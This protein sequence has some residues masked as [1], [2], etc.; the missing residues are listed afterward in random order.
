MHIIEPRVDLCNVFNNACHM[1]HISRSRG[2]SDIASY[3]YK[4]TM[5]YWIHLCKSAY[6][7]LVMDG[8][9]S[10]PANLFDRRLIIAL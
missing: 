5:F 8:N 3:Y 6:P 2:T 4:V 9:T 10:P 7:E 1:K